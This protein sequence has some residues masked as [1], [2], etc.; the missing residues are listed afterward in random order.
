MVLTSWPLFWTTPLSTTNGKT[1]CEPCTN[2]SL[3]CDDCSTVNSNNWVHLVRGNISSSKQV[4]TIDLSFAKNNFFLRYVCLYRLESSSVSNLNSTA[5]YLSDEWRSYQCLRDH[6][7]KCRWSCAKVLRCDY[8]SD[9]W[10]ETLI[11]L[12]NGLKWFRSTRAVLHTFSSACLSMG[13][14]CFTLLVTWVFSSLFNDDFQTDACSF[15]TYDLFFYGTLNRQ[16]ALFRTKPSLAPM[17]NKLDAM[18]HTDRCLI[19]IHPLF[20]M[21][22]FSF[23]LLVF[24]ILHQHKQQRAERTGQWDLISRV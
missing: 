4:R 7:T 5:S 24:M 10:V 13:L 20:F 3:Q 19:S 21:R 11:L 8:A 23:Y 15:C 2:G 6:I 22:L 12:V 9:W 14:P 1:M 16:T 18:L 17:I